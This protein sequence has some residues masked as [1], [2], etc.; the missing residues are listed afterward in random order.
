MILA[1]ICY[2]IFKIYRIY[3]PSQKEK[4]KNTFRFLTFFASGSLIIFAVS[5]YVLWRCIQNFDKGLG[6]HLLPEKRQVVGR[7][8]QFDTAFEI[9]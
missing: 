8:G 7:G 6:I 4:Y 9:Y 1:G 3:E 2:F 5:I